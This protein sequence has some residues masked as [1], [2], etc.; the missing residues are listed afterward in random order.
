MHDDQNLFYTAPLEKFLT[1]QKPCFQPCKI[2]FP[3]LFTFF[4]A[5]K[6]AVTGLRQSCNLPELKQVE[7]WQGCKSVHS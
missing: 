7:Q 6:L 5:C 1:L 2:L 3:A 4:Q